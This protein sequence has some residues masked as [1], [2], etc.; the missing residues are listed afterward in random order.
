MDPLDSLAGLV[1]RC[2]ALA[3]R[4]AA[5]YHTGCEWHVLDEPEGV[6]F[7]VRRLPGEAGWRICCQSR[8]GAEKALNGCQLWAKVLFLRWVQDFF[9]HYRKK[10]EELWAQIETVV[11]QAEK[12]LV[13][14]EGL[15]AVATP[16]GKAVAEGVQEFRRQL[17]ESVG[18]LERALAGHNCDDKSGACWHYK[19]RTL[20]IDLGLGDVTE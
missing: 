11:P 4:Y 16:E 12:T 18:L 19:A 1:E 5:R 13:R 15:A 14:L 6:A 20:V 7:I 9:I 17:N 10:G 3:A 2:D 8:D